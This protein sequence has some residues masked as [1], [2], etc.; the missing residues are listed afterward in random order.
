[1]AEIMIKMGVNAPSDQTG[2]V[3]KVLEHIYEQ[4]PD[5]VDS[6]FR[7][8]AYEEDFSYSAIGVMASMSFILKYKGKDGET[9][10]YTA[11][12]LNAFQRT[13]ED[14]K[15]ALDIIISAGARNLLRIVYEQRAREDNEEERSRF[16]Q[17][18]AEELGLA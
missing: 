9:K 1:M 12:L 15:P 14:E 17:D 3:L 10:E 18:K 8:S 6:P 4:T 5:M 13:I 7:F 16:V 2:I 11:P